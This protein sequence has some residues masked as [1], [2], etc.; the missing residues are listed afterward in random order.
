MQIFEKYVIKTHKLYNFLLWT[1]SE[2]LVVFL[3]KYVRNDELTKNGHQEFWVEKLFLVPQPQGQVSAQVP[4]VPTHYT[5]TRTRVEP[6]LSALRPTA[7]TNR[8]PCIRTIMG[9]QIVQGCYAVAWDRFE[10]ATLR[11]QG[12]EHTVTRSRPTIVCAREKVWRH[13]R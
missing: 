10:R 8:P 5:V 1:A 13:D 2:G 11:L 4:K 7:L 3:A 12:A 6:V 9:E